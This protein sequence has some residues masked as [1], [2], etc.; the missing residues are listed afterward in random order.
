MVGCI[1]VCRVGCDSCLFKLPEGCTMP[2]GTVKWFDCKKGFGFLLDDEG[3]E[4]FIHYTV[5][6]GDGFR[7]LR[8]GEKVEYEA[9]T[10]PKGI[11]ATRVRRIEPP[12]A[13]PRAAAEKDSEPPDPEQA[14]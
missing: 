1:W 10:G 7:R 4:V 2:V 3:N 11:L 6:E 12:P 14:S 9:S 5:I 8:D 13:R